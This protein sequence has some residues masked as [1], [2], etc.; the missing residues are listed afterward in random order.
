MEAAARG[1]R[2][3]LTAQVGRIEEVLL[4]AKAEGGSHGYTANYTPVRLM[5]GCL[6][7]GQVVCVRITGVEG[8]CCVA[9]PEIENT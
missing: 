2:R 6:P 1:S 4:E 9:R 5:D 3:F 8:E 7:A